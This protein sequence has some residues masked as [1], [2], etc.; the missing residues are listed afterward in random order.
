MIIILI[1]AAII[2]FVVAARGHDAKEFFEPVLILAIVF[3]NAFMGV[4]QESK[5]EKAM[6]ALK[7]LSA[8]HARVVRGGK[9]MVVD[10]AEL[11]PGDIVI[12]DKLCQH[13]MD[14]TPLGDALGL[15]SGI[16]KIYFEADGN[17][18]SILKAAAGDINCKAFVGTIAT[19]DKFIASKEDKKAIASE[20][21]A[22][23]CEMEGGA[24][25]HVAYVNR[26]PFAVIR[27]ISD[28][29]DGNAEMNY[30]EFLKIAAERSSA[31]THKLI[32]EYK[33]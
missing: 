31:L 24:V 17:A 2:S 25:A 9:E 8:P 18:V 1:V 13:D 10:A 6:D 12:A 11:V 20:F 5:A 29:A 4:M 21:S 33:A 23:A 22:Y 15:I 3:L 27:A 32:E 26:T 14:T 30:I 28:S 7:S 16:N 19:G